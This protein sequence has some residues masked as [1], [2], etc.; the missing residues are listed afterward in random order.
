MVYGNYANKLLRLQ[1]DLLQALDQHRRGHKQTV[2]TAQRPTRVA[3][4]LIA[5]SG[6][7]KI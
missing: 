5:A 7:A 4:L 6:E 2:M 3:G 1:L